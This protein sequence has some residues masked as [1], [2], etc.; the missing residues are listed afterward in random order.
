MINFDNFNLFDPKVGIVPYTP[1]REASS[2]M[3]KARG[4]LWNRN[5]DEIKALAADA[6]SIIE[7]YF[8]QERDA[9]MEQ[10][11]T[12]KRYELLES[13]CDG[14]IQGIRDEAADEYDVFNRDTTSDVDALA[15]AIDQ[16]FDPTTIDQIKDPEPFELFAALSLSCLANYVKTTKFSLDLKTM[17]RVPRTSASFTSYEV[18][19]MS[20][21]VFEA[22]ELANYSEGLRNKERLEKKFEERLQQ[23]RSQQSDSEQQLIEKIRTETLE[24]V[25]EEEQKARSVKARENNQARHQKNHEAKKVVTEQ[26]AAD[27]RRFSTLEAAGEYYVQVLEQM[28]FDH[29]Q[30]T[31]VKWL[32]AKARELEIRF[33]T[34][35]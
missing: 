16:L 3:Y 25:R 22:M 11:K 1:I 8:D 31:V 21:M 5:A 34:K 32:S 10:I 24:A 29:K 2:V 13:D 35:R 15:N 18:S 19:H 33:S 28:G 26:W 6:D 12:D 27:P 23:Y 20:S 17:S 30:R 14:N 7:A 4:L 9:L